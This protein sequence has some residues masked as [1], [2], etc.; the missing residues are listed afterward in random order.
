M[1]ARKRFSEEPGYEGIDTF[2]QTGQMWKISLAFLS[3]RSGFPETTS[4]NTADFLKI[5]YL[6]HL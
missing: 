4:I 1:H 6:K 2:S 3:N 5:F